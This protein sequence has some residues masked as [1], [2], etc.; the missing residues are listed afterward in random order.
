MN[1]AHQPARIVN[2]TIYDQGE[3]YLSYSDTDSMTDYFHG[4][5]AGQRRTA[6]L[7]RT[8]G[9]EVVKFFAN[10]RISE[11]AERRARQVAKWAGYSVA[12]EGNQFVMTR[13]QAA[14]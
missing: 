1:T 13:H 6:D 2:G 11:A 8:D 14:H 4:T 7:L 5:S 12:I 9:A 3:N 10:G